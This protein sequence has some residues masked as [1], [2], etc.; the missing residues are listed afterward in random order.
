MVSK[1]IVWLAML[2]MALFLAGCSEP[3][4]LAA[5][6][7]ISDDLAQAR[8]LIKQQTPAS[9]AQAEKILQDTLRTPN[10]TSVAKQGA[11]ELLATLLSEVTAR[12]FT[13]EQFAKLQQDFAQA[14]SDLHY[15]L[16]RLCAEAAGFAYSAGLS[17][18]DSQTLQQY[19]R[20]LAQ[21]VPQAIIDKDNAE[22]IRVGLEQ[23]LART[24]QEVSRMRITAEK[25]FLKAESL[26]GDEYV[27]TVAQ[28]AA[29]QLEADRLS[30]R[31][32]N[33][34]LALQSARQDEFSRQFQL[35]KLQ[36]AVQR[37]EQQISAQAGSLDQVRQ[38][39]DTA[40]A[41]LQKSADELLV[42]LNSFG[43]LGTQL[44]AA[45]Q[46]LMDQQGQAISHYGKAL[47]GAAAGSK[48]FRDFKSARPADS[49]A[50]QRVDMLISVDAQVDL[51]VSLTRAEILRASMRQDYVGLLER[52][53]WRAKQVEDA[54]K[55]L[56]AV[57]VRMGSP[58]I[59]AASTQQSIQQVCTTAKG[60]LSS[61]IQTLR[62]TAWPR[63]KK[64]DSAEQMV[65]NL[66]GVRWN[67][68]VWAMLGLAHQARA[69]LCQQMGDEQEARADS[70]AASVYLSSAGRIR[71]GLVRLTGSN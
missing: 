35:A 24:R 3:P 29:G 7:K 17:L 57:G 2:M 43:E 19:R 15:A 49:P 25:S 44:D 8:D 12:Q 34:E 66:E 46:L 41:K 33:E 58:Q 39:R 52:V 65:K 61:A 37:V 9:Y 70:Q 5:S 56:T 22:K 30:I 11:H 26:S 71:P 47:V 13:D 23:R 63:Q 16:S 67:W 31:A 40:K 62:A 10:A 59:D 14:D 32:R 21:M 54:R 38:A 6:K 48:R 4:E 1:Q 55:A 64:A 42:Q 68:Q 69:A 50:D 27:S 18:S 53:S 60:D 20:T 36:E 28:A 51:A 45:Y